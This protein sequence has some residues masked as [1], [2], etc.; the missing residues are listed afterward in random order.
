M[1]LDQEMC[2]IDPA[3]V[4]K[5]VYKRQ[6]ASQIKK[7]RVSAVVYEKEIRILDELKQSHGLKNDAEAVRFAII[8]TE[9][10]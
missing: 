8:K 7:K 2:T 5:L 3:L 9:E 6:N 1:S 10:N 4:N